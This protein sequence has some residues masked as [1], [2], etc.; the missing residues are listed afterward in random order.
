[1]PWEWPKK[2]SQRSVAAQQLRNLTRICEGAGSIPGLAQ[3]V[4][5]LALL[6]P[7][8]RLAVTALIQPLAWEPPY[9]AGTKKIFLKVK[10]LEKDI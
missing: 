10:G 7:C 6:G 2:K 4:E 5:D 3:W 8:C 9:A 1:M